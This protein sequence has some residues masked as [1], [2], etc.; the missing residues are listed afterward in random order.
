MFVEIVV[1]PLLMRALFGEKLKPLRAEIGSHVSRSVAFFLGA[2]QHEGINY[3]GARSAV[4]ADPVR[5][6]DVQAK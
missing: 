2:C 5:R 6:A 1:L 4:L 3:P